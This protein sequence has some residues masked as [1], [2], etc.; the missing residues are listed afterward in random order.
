MTKSKRVLVGFLVILAS[1][2][3]AS[4]LLFAMRDGR[5]DGSPPIEL[6]AA[7]EVRAMALGE[8]LPASDIVT[9]AAPTGQDAGR[10]ATIN[11]R[12]GQSVDE[13]NIL[14][15]LD[16]QSALQAQ[17]QQ[18]EADVEQKLAALA[19]LKADL[20]SEEKSLQAQIKQQ[21][22]ERDRAEWD[23]EKHQKLT[24][25][26]LYENPVLIDKRLALESA[27]QKLGNLEISLERN[28]MRSA[29]GVRVDEASALADLA[30]A[31]ASAVK[32]RADLEKAFVRAPIAGRILSLSGK[33]G[34][35]IGSNGFADIGDTSKMVV[36]A[37]V[38]ETD[39]EKLTLGV[40]C[41][42]R[43]RAIDEALAGTLDRIGVR[44]SKQSI[45]STDPAAIVDAR[46]VEVW[47]SLDE[48]SSAKVADLSG[49]QVTVEFQ[50]GRSGNA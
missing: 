35:Q 19:K 23:L 17:R 13:G 43:S 7:T 40:D 2:A 14:A 6:V 41:E 48:R 27:N 1:V 37:E 28:R 10:I 31:E 3:A 20:A 42:V 18:A 39:L 44:I 11:V 32:A 21:Q 46:V 12:E 24:S 47:I 38:F 34:E 36:R 50:P 26:G 9:V 33:I 22:A 25:A 49:L 16:T 15:T 5:G 30:A 29:D 45:V 8:I 4:A